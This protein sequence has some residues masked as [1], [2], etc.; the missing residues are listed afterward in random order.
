MNILKTD[1]AKCNRARAL[2]ID[3]AIVIAVGVFM[4]WYAVRG[5]SQ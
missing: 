1:C 3:W 2:L 4:G 5:L